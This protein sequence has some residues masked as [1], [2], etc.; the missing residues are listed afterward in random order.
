MQRS[1]KYVLNHLPSFRV[2]PDTC[3]HSHSTKCWNSS[4]WIQSAHF[5]SR[6]LVS[7][8]LVQQSIRPG[9]NVGISFMQVG[10]HHN[11]VRVCIIWYI[12]SLMYDGFMRHPNI[13]ACNYLKMCSCILADS[14]AKEAYNGPF[15]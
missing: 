5:S 13:Y 9:Q 10:I 6:Q 11:D 7:H 3:S 14:S 15:L 12:S 1:I 2:W 4:I 8:C